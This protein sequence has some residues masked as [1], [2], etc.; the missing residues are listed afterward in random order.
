MEIGESLLTKVAKCLMI[1]FPD[2][3]SKRKFLPKMYPS[4]TVVM[5]DDPTLACHPKND[6]GPSQLKICISSYEPVP[7]KSAKILQ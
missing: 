2:I 5:P 7:K 4:Q 6:T 3:P 1:C